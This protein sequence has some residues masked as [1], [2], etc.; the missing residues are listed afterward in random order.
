MAATDGLAFFS[1]TGFG[2]RAAWCTEINDSLTIEGDASES[3]HN[4][5]FYTHFVEDGRFSVQVV[6]ATYAEWRAFSVW[7]QRYGVLVTSPGNG[8]GVIHIQVPSRG[9]KTTGIPIGGIAFGDTAGETVRTLNL[10]FESV[11]GRLRPGDRGTTLEPLLPKD[12]QAVQFY[13]SGTQ[14]PA[15]RSHED[16]IYDG[17]GPLGTNDLENVAKMAAARRAAARGGV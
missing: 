17:Q 8:I 14:L 10:T 12:S 11:I 4:S 1:A 16:G 7:M 2:S 6:F 13:P 15:D 9:F 5:T 3:R